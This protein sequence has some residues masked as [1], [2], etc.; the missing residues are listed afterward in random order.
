[1]Q[2]PA[3][4]VAERRAVARST[5]A[6]V[7]SNADAAHLRHLGFPR[8]VETVPNA[9]DVP[10]APPGVVAAP[11]ILFL[12]SYH[13][14]PNIIA[15]ERLIRCIWPRIYARVPAARLLI[16]GAESERLPSRSAA[17]PGVEFRGFVDDLATIY[18]ES[19]LVCTPITTGSGTRLKLLEA[20]AYARPMVST[21]I[22]A[23][24]LGFR[25][26]HEI[27]LREDDASLAEVCIA[28]LRDDALC[29]RYGTTARDMVRDRFDV[30][31]VELAIV[32]LIRDACRAA[33]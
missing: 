17:P 32:D 2:L 3:L 14:P 7:C 13:H 29:A 27:M 11:S 20:A 25:D 23:E 8:Q 6:F 9:I 28:L 31:R 1:M 26:N 30:R 12:G 4:L 22:G 15:A 24:G 16:A 10:P 18:A 19:R 33:P 21:R 5:R